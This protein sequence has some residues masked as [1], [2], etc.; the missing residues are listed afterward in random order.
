[1][2][3][4]SASKIIIFCGHYGSGKTNAA[5][6][7]AVELRRAFPRERVALLD[8]DVVNPFFRS[9]DNGEY[10]R[11]NG[12][13]LIA[14][15][16]ANT[17]VDVPALPPEIY[18]VFTAGAGR[19]V[20]DVGGDAAGAAALGALAERVAGI[21]YEMLYVIN[22]YRPLTASPEAAAGMLREI[23]GRCGLRASAIINNSNLGAETTRE[24]VERSFG[25]AAEVCARTR[26]PLRATTVLR[27]I[28]GSFGEAERAEHR[29]APIE[30][31]TKKLY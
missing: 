5:V 15:R 6:N 24:T 13:A 11:E 1:M 7:A 12:V 26:L 10:L 3:I 21:G 29:I 19:F 4:E 28:Y 30:N 9:A 22:K 8:M 20:L 16:Y 2:I 23:E 14:P 25:Y 18:S 27:E 31:I 17:N